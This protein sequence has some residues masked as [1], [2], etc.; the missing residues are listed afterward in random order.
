MKHRYNLNVV[1]PIPDGGHIC[2]DQ[3][4]YIDQ[5]KVYYP[6]L[7]YNMNKRIWVGKAISETQMHPN[8]TYQEQF[9]TEYAAITHLNLPIYSKRVGMYAAALK[10]AEQIGLY[11]DLV[12]YLGPRNANLAMDFAVYSMVATGNAIKDFEVEMQESML[13]LG[14]VYS[15]SWIGDIIANEITE[16]QV[17][18]FKQAWLKRF[19]GDELQNIWICIDGSNNDC[20]ADIDEAEKGKTKSHTS[21]DYIRFLYAV[22]STGMPIYSMVYRGDRVD[23]KAIFEM[24]S[25]LD[26]FKIKP[27]GV[28]LD[29]GFCDYDCIQALR[30]KQLEFVIMMKENANG[31]KELLG[32]YHDELR[33]KWNYALGHGLFGASDTVTLFKKRDLQLNCALIW[34]AKNGEERID[35]L[36]DELL[37]L[38]DECHLTLEE[39]KIP[40]I[41]S[42]YSKY[43]T[44]SA[45]KTSVI[46]HDDIIQSEISGKGYYGLACSGIMTAKEANTVYDLR[47]S[48]EKQYAILKSQLGGDVF[49][50]HS[51]HGIAVRETF[52]FVASI[53][54][55]HICMNQGLRKKRIDTNTAIKELKL[56]NLTLLP[57]NKYQ[58][59]HNQSI[60]QKDILQALGLSV[61]N[62]DY[63]ADYETK[64]INKEMVHPVQKLG[65]L[66]AE[67]PA[68][69]GS[70]KVQGKPEGS[71]AMGKGSRSNTKQDQSVE[72]NDAG[73]KP[74]SDGSSKAPQATVNTAEG[75][76]RGPGRPKGS[77]N[78]P[79]DFSK[80][81]RGPG[82]PKG[83]KNKPKS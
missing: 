53:L 49:R 12:K 44:L 77:K 21:S 29:R 82:R 48:S 79:K 14:K 16:D 20:D 33:Y 19:T 11:D 51:M 42:K 56:I 3:R 70:Q 41:P 35:Y 52:A 26:A 60:R 31:Y 8:E 45:D 36:I 65:S 39:G 75:Q 40:A 1:V 7:K 63:L 76:R 74:K 27:K 78:K 81:T 18:A 28:V 72:S 66:A 73:K 71:K 47:D 68:S 69:N 64:R 37:D 55:N 4:V 24:I 9:P 25:I 10:I 22:T 34:D 13:F 59:V 67:K 62:L 43:L 83:S 50:A 30:A 61:D 58:L 80:P 57:G 32:K 54:R 17:I 23:C 38:I 6:D 15:D 5:E 46:V 2:K